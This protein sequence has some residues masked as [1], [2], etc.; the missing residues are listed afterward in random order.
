MQ[1]FTRTLQQKTVAKWANKAKPA[2]VQ[3]INRLFTKTTSS[4]QQRLLGGYFRQ[5][6]DALEPKK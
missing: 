6:Y 3:K 2:M 4:T 1:V 5:I